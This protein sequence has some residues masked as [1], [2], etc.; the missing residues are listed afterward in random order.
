[1]SE[2]LTENEIEFSVSQITGSLALSGIVV[3][4]DM[5]EV[6][7]K[8]LRKEISAESATQE[9]LDRCS[10]HVQTLNNS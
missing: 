6:G 2:P 7:R 5:K 4:N 10:L 3:S 1:M 8:I 9:V